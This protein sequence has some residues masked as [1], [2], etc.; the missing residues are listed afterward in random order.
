MKRKSLFKKL[1]LEGRL[2]LV[3]PSRAIESSYLKKS[4]SHLSSAKLL[5]ENERLEETVSLTYYS[6]YYTSQ[7][8][9]FRTGIKC[10]NH[11]ATIILLKK[12]FGIDNTDI[13]SAKKERIDKQY[14]IDLRVVEEEVHELIE[15]AEDF[16]SRIYDF[17]DRL[18]N[19]K[20]NEFRKKTKELISK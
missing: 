14:Y 7:A 13:K 3:E 5:L 11:T 18:S 6:M 17:I 20:V 4:E 19:E 8:L 10:E 16:N 2:E 12:V 1:N 15:T 9:L